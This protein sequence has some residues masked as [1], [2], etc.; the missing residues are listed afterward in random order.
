M[1]NTVSDKYLQKDSPLGSHRARILHLDGIR[2]A[3]ALAVVFCHYMARMSEQTGIQKFIGRLFIEGWLGVDVFFALSGFLITG[4][5]LD[6]QKSS[7]FFS[8]FYIRRFFRLAPLYYLYIAIIFAGQAYQRSLDKTAV[9]FNIFYLQNFYTAHLGHWPTGTGLLWSLAV[10]EHFYLLWPAVIY[11]MRPRKVA[12]LSLF[13]SFASFLLRIYLY[14]TNHGFAGYVLTFSRVDS[15]CIGALAALSIR[16]CDPFGL[17][18]FLRFARWPLW[19]GVALMLTYSVLGY[20]APVNEMYGPVIVGSLTACLI[21]NPGLWRV[22]LESSWLRWVGR[23]SYAVYVWQFLPW[24]LIQHWVF[25]HT[26]SLPVR[27]A[28]VIVLVALL[29]LQAKLSWIV[30]EGPML[31]LR[32]RLFPSPLKAKAAKQC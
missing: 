16:G 31:A 7:G 15:L 21:V 3:A 30:L 24:I 19:V 25:A 32:E 1:S 27:L 8:R 10:E 11:F 13:L 17:Q 18:T 6:E 5:L 23:Y 26:T 14:Q 4:I 28:S 22:V 12:Y 2:G 9:I 20:Q 29:L